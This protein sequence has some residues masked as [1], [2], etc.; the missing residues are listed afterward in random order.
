[1]P[2]S[3]HEELETLQRLYDLNGTLAGVVAEGMLGFLGYAC[4]R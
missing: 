4:G 3:E 2:T 1:M